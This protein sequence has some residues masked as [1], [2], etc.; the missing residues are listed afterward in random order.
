MQIEHT[1]AMEHVCKELT[2]V[3][4]FLSLCCHPGHFTLTLHLRID[5]ASNVMAAVWPL[6]FTIALNLRIL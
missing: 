2:F 3:N 6:K 4:D 5:K 1:L